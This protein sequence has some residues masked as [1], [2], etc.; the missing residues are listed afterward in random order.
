MR[1]RDLPELRE[2]V[3]EL[4][5]DVALERARLDAGRTGDRKLAEAI[6]ARLAAD[7]SGGSAVSE[8]ASLIRMAGLTPEGSYL[9]VA[10]RADADPVAGPNAKR[11]RGDLAEELAVPYA[12]GAVVAPLGEEM[13]VLAPAAGRT[14][15]GRG[16][17][18]ARVRG[19][20][21]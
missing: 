12:V 15:P 6:V 2:S 4:A 16:V 8:I 3:V 21:A 10:M 14:G 13:I 1:V 17:G 18:R 7:T 19:A 9:V 20:A 11:W 5:A